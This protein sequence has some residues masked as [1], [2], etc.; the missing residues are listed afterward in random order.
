M[1]LVRTL[2]VIEVDVAGD[3]RSQLGH[4]RELVQEDHLVLEAAPE[5]LNDDVVETPALAV[6]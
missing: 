3:P 1:R 4:R 2:V 5:A 6:H